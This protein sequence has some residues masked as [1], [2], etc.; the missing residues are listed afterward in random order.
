MKMNKQT[1]IQKITVLCFLC[2]LFFSNYAQQI[3]RIQFKG[4]NENKVILTLECWDDDLIHFR[5]GDEKTNGKMF[6]NTTPSIAKTDYIGATEFQQNGNTIETRDLKIVYNPYNLTVTMIDKQQ[7]DL[8]LV[9]FTPTSVD[10]IWRGFKANKKSHTH[11]FGLGQEFDFSKLGST[12]FDWD[13][14]KRTS[15][16]HGNEMVYANGG[17]TGNTQIPILYALHS[18]KYENYAVLYDNE[19]KQRWN[20]T[21]KDEW[22]A[23]A[24]GGEV[25]FFF[26]H[27]HD[28]KDLR[29]DFM[30]LTGKPPIPPKKMFGLWV[31]EFGYD[32]WEEVDD[33]LATL[34]KNNFPLDGF[35]LDLQWFGGIK[36]ENPQM[37]KLDWDTKNFPN[38]R[39]KILDYDQKHGVGIM[40]I[41]EP[42]IDKSQPE[43]NDLAKAGL[44][45]TYSTDRKNALVLPN[46]W[47]GSGG[48]FDYS[49]PKTQHYIHQNKRLKLINDGVIGHWCDLGEPENYNDSAFYYG[50]HH[51][52][53]HNLF[54]LN[55]A[56]GVFEG[57]KS[58]RILQR[59]FILGRSGAAG[60]QRYGVA[61]W[62]GDISSRI[63]SLAAQTAGQANMSFSGVD[64][65]GSD[66]GG[67]HRFMDTT[68]KVDLNDAY[69]RWYAYGALCEIP[70]RPHTS[71]I[72][73]ARQNETAPDRI[74][75]IKSNLDNTRLRYALTP[76]LYSLAY[77]AYKN[78]EPIFSPLVY[79]YQT[80]KHIN[81]LGDHKMIGENLLFA[82]STVEKEQT[83]N[84]YLP[85]GTWFDFYSN[86]SI[87][88]KGKFI[89]KVPLYRDNLFKLPLYAKA[90]A[91]I[92][93]MY[94]DE[95]T[96]NILG[97]RT[98]D[99]QRNELILKIFADENLKEFL[100]YEDDGK[101][102]HYLEDDFRTIVLEQGG[103][104]DEHRITIGAAKGSY[105][106]DENRH[107]IIELITNK[108]TKGISVNGVSLKAYNSLQE[109]NENTSGF[110]IE[111]NL[112]IIK[113][114]ATAVSEEQKVLVSW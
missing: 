60:I 96:M 64:Y 31:S 72:D 57:Y 75:D 35:V 97:K 91:I 7:K 46:A 9:S 49:N 86:K 114:K 90:G 70:I 20:F 43:F 66:I 108:K 85:A 112:I 8:V 58:S 62:S 55:W 27:G 11:F 32:N 107:T 80:D 18:S 33:K 48:M 59:P 38:P 95:K 17:A 82:A 93:M 61:M 23:E 94:V 51:K 5:F 83:K 105:K 37:G 109:L 79:Y 52:D 73:T 10:G 104:N 25:D 71:N 19:Y 111:N 84:V 81:N 69:T 89:N 50:G 22:T 113:T 12:N 65:Y 77:K 24:D 68:V 26:F 29:K 13:G 30:E 4:N 98:D 110:V 88:G 40:T 47:W 28:L 39:T 42:Y 103:D 63:T 1:F 54:A 74:G 45:A 78:G 102:T 100:L 101:T 34:R 14:K 15:G 56:K 21:Q 41:E 3:Q 76:Y 36:K 2:L 53:I 67:F 16:K 106:P 92:P 87:K 6:I 99:T 44:L